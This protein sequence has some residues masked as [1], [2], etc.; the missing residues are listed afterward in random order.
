MNIKILEKGEGVTSRIG[1]VGKMDE[2]CFFLVLAR[3][4]I[5]TVKWDQVPFQ[6]V[7]ESK[8]QSSV[9]RLPLCLLFQKTKKQTNLINTVP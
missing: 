1:K 9:E 6:R 7:V 4:W 2:E 8:T 5:L 3:M